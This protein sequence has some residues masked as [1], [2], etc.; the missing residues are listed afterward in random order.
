MA[1]PFYSRIARQ[2]HEA[3]GFEGGPFKKYVLNDYLI[4]KIDAIQDRD[5][6]ELG[7]GNGYFA[8]LM[9]QRFAGQQAERHVVS[10]LSGALLDIA[11]RDCGIKTAEY[12]QLDLRS[13]FPFDDDSFDLILATMVFNECS[14]AAVRGALRES[15]RVLRHDGRLLVTI[16]HPLFIRHLSDKGKLARL[17]AQFWTMPGKASL[18][19]PVVIR[20]EERYAALF[21]QAGFSFSTASLHPT[22]HV[23][24]ERP[25]LRHAKGL[26][27]ALVFDCKLNKRT[28]AEAEPASR[29]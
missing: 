25:G 29:G 2:W 20:S 23:L 26:P 28:D 6:L 4:N 9:T 22:S 8:R 12:L 27:L 15:A 17:G 13:T 19:L 10:E 11:R 21:S 3:T 7:A 16:T 1:R 18:R 14:D 5:I 24:N